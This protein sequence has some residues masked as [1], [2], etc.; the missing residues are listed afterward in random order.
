MGSKR[1]P[2]KKADPVN[3]STEAVALAA[4]QEINELRERVVELT[5]HSVAL[6]QTC[7]ALAEAL[8]MTKEATTAPGVPPLHLVRL[9]VGQRDRWRDAAM[10]NHA[11]PGDV[12]S[13]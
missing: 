7:Y 13:S 9:L 10:R 6:N 1:K 5:A 8:D 4:A 3:I 2:V 11:G 12:Q